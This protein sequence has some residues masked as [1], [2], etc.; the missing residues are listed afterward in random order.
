[1]IH[2]NNHS[3]T[4]KPTRS[5]HP[6]TPGDELR[7]ATLKKSVTQCLIS[8]GSI[9]LLLPAL[10]VTLSATPCS[11]ISKSL[12]TPSSQFYLLSVTQLLL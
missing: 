9:L 11:P 8:F 2:I 6:P 10:A 1:M 5:K 7:L 12:F 3:Q 4:H